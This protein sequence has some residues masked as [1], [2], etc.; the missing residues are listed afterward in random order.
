MVVNK[1]RK[2]K[3]KGLPLFILVLVLSIAGSVYAAGTS[4]AHIS[5][6]ASSATGTTV[7]ATGASGTLA[8]S[9]S[10]PAFYVQGYAKKQINWWPDSTVASAIAY[11]SQT[12]KKSF[13]A[14]NGSFYYAEAYTQ[15]NATSIYGEAK[16]TV[17]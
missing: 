14:E 6:G 10:G 17:N 4:I 5:P 9:S 3:A 2:T 7:K 11:P 8:V 12:V 13:T 16:V 1:A 15:A